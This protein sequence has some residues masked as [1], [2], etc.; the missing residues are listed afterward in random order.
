MVRS[1][2]DELLSKIL[3]WIFVTHKITIPVSPICQS[4]FRS[5]YK[6]DRN[7]NIAIKGF[8]NNKNSYLKLYP[9]FAQL[10]Q[11]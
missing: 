6:V 10:V 1:E 3:R 8:H 9:R 11:Y 7:G 4:N 5:Y 2:P